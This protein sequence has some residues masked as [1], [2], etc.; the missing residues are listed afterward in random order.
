M[1]LQ[2]QT[3]LLFPCNVNVALEGLAKLLNTIKVVQQRLNIELK[4]D[5]LLLTMYDTRLR[6]SNQ[7]VEEVKKHFQKM[8]FNT[9]IIEM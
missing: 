1:H 5:G 4:I 2:P 7:V 3:P 9:I 6:L 8:V